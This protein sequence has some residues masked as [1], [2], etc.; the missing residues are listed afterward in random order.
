MSATVF[1]L[2]GLVSLP[3]E[4]VEPTEAVDSL[5]ELADV[6]PVEPPSTGAIFPPLRSH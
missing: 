1:A 5:V 6:V 3:A 4:L 2:V